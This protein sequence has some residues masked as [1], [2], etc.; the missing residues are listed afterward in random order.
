MPSGLI[1]NPKPSNS[2]TENRKIT[3]LKD[4]EGQI[5]LNLPSL[6]HQILKP[7]AGNMPPV[8]FAGFRREKPKHLHASTLNTDTTG[9]ASPGHLRSGASAPSPP[10]A[11]R[12][13]VLKGLGCGGIVGTIR[14]C[15][16]LEC[17][18]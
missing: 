17:K 3:G 15:E 4:P 18:S 5:S 2:S 12:P 14:G 1:L 9:D 6:D 10:H 16:G 8:L 13:D 7:E 11:M